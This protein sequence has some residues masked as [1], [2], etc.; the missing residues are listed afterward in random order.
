M[1]VRRLPMLA[2]TVVGL[3]AIGLVDREATDPVPASFGTV[4]ASWMPSAPSGTTLTG[5]WFCPGVPAGGRMARNT[6]RRARG[7]SA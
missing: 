1:I 7:N 5:T 3:A 4:A 2:V 6:D